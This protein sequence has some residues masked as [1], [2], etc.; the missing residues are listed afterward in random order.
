[1]VTILTP[2]GETRVENAV[3]EGE[4]LWI[5]LA[6]LENATGWEWSEDGLCRDQ[7]CVP[8][9]AP[10]ELLREEH[11]SRS[12][13]YAAFARHRGEPLLR[14]ANGDVWSQVERGESSAAA[15]LQAPDFELPDVDGHRH[16]LSQYRGSKVFLVTWA[17]W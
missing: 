8:L 1:M 2:N 9:P 6:A 12:L 17:S 14:G 13:N 16:R 5:P 7:L 15:G 4:E 10:D 3:V 11:G